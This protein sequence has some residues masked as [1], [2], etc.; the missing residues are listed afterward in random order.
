MTWETWKACAK[1][2]TIK[3]IRR[4]VE[5]QGKRGMEDEL[6]RCVGPENKRG[7]AGAD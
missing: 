2:A 3:S 4:K 1:L 5:K 6:Q 7:R